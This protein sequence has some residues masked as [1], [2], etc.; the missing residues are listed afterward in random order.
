[1]KTSTLAIEDVSFLVLMVSFTLKIIER[2]R[3]VYKNELPSDFSGTVSKLDIKLSTKTLVIKDHIYLNIGNQR[4]Q[5]LPRLCF[6]K[7]KIV[8][9]I[10]AV[11]FHEWKVCDNSS[12]SK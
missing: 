12:V 1:M 7:L 2:D 3:G 8:Y 10:A 5:S 9:F 6:G 11:I 4:L